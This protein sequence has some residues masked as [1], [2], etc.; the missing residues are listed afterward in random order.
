MNI[1]RVHHVCCE[2][3][4]LYCKEWMA[5]SGGLFCSDLCRQRMRQHLDGEYRRIF[6][7]ERLRRT[8]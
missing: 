3:Q 1:T 8:R 7:V 2:H 4:C 5:C 6:P